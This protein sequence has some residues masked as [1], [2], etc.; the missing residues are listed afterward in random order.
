MNYLQSAIALNNVGVTHLSGGDHKRAIDAF[1]KANDALK[2]TLR[3]SAAEAA[4]LLPSSQH[5]TTNELSSSL[6]VEV[7]EYKEKNI[8]AFLSVLQYGPSMSVV[9]PVLVSSTIKD[10]NESSMKAILAFNLGVAYYCLSRSKRIRGSTSNAKAALSHASSYLQKAQELFATVDPKLA[11]SCDRS[12][13]AQRLLALSFQGVILNTLCQAL[14][15]EGYRS[16]AQE[17][18]EAVAKVRGVLENNMRKVPMM[19]KIT[20]SA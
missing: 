13:I 12:S 16:E 9:H 19:T 7:L 14:L 3:V 10:N 18:S 11:G 15:E 17:A 8:H 1:R 6:T 20:A 2:H 5:T 4:S